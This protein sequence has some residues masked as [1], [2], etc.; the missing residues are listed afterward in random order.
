MYASQS[1]IKLMSFNRSTLWSCVWVYWCV[2]RL[3][4]QFVKWSRE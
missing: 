2:P 1:T 3:Q 4:G